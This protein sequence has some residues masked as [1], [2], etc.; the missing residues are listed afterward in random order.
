MNNNKLQNKR[1]VSR[2]RTDVSSSGE[3]LTV[4]TLSEFLC[5]HPSTIYRLI[6]HR[7]IPAFQL[8]ADWR[9]HKPDIERWV[10]ERTLNCSNPFQG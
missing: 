7:S 4:K 9:F 5:C 8:G 10:R 3:I 2:S 6:K 1:D